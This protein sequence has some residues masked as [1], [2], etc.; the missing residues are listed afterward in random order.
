MMYDSFEKKVLE[1]SYEEEPMKKRRRC[2][3]GTEE[4][5]DD[6]IYLYIY[7]HLVKMECIM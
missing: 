1:N 6:V 2:E 3:V 4:N 7:I 5:Q